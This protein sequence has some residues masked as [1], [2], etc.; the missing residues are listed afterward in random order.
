MNSL[1]L[2]ED[3][4]LHKDALNILLDDSI[5]CGYGSHLT[6]DHRPKPSAE[7]MLY[8]VYRNLY[9]EVEKNKQEKT[10]IITEESYF[11]NVL[12][13]CLRMPKDSDLHKWAK[14]T[15]A[16]ASAVNYENNV[17]P[18]PTDETAEWLDEIMG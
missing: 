7:Q 4:L 2:K 13:R 3:V 12:L 1:I 18:E 16:V 10:R 5:V 8:G 14:K 11:A 6:E 9:E 17:A 15:L